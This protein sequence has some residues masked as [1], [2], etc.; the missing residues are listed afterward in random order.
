MLEKVQRRAVGMVTNFKGRS[1]EEK[2]AEAGMITLEARRRR[3]DLIQAYR[4]INEVDDV[5]SSLW[6]DKTDVRDDAR[7]TRQQT[8]YINVKR[9]DG[10]TEIRRNF[11][12]QRVTDPWNN[13]PDKVKQAKS[14]NIFK[15]GIDNLIFKV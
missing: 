4:I 2:L 3:G 11:W 15:N 5:D 10:K 9:G 1:Y 7:N 12:S 13:L 8:G 6:F 14:T